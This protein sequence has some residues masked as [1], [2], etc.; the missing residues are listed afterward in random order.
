[1]DFREF[2]AQARKVRLGKRL[3]DAVYLHRSAID[4]LSAE[5]LGQVAKAAEAH[6]DSVDSWN[7]LKISTKNHRITF[8]YYPEFFDD[9]FPSLAASHTVDLESDT[10][11]TASYRKSKNPPILHRCELLLKPDHPSAEQLAEITAQAEAAGLYENTRRIGFKEQWARAI[12]SKGLTFVDGRFRSTEEAQPS[13]KQ[14]NS[15]EIQRHLTAINRDKLSAPMQVLARHGYLDGGHSVFDY[16]CGRGDD[17]REL[18]AHGIDV[19]GWDPV[20]RPETPR[21]TADF[22]NL[23]FVINVIEDTGER[24]DAL[25]AAFSL[26]RKAL[27]VAAMIGGD[28]TTQKFAAYG[29]GV[30]T[31]RNTFQKYFAQEE[32]RKYLEE[33]LSERAIAVAPGIFIIFRDELEEQVFLSERVRASQEWKQLTRRVAPEAKPRASKSMVERN[34]ELFDDFW[35][36]CLHLGRVPGNSEFDHSDRL[37]SVAGSHRKAFEAAQDFYDDEFELAEERRRNELLV[38]FAMESFGRR[39]PYVA[40]PESLQRDIKSFFGKYSTVSEESKRILYSAADTGRILKACEESVVRLGCGFM[41]PGHSLTLHRSLL[42]E[43]PPLLQV[44]VGCATQLYG[45]I[46]DIDLVK[47]HTTSGKVSLLEFDDFVGLPIPSLRRRTKINLRRLQVDVFRY[48][49]D[50]DFLPT[51]LLLKSRFMRDGFPKFKE[52]S[53]FDDQLHRLA[54]LQLLDTQS[55]PTAQLLSQIESY[56]YAID[57]FDIVP[58]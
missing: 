28:A 11:R 36:L 1:M 33:A 18:E 38:Y 41:E 24:T 54:W 39:R 13:S 14:N 5:L 17:I 19:S 20:Y 21:V 56:G 4:G 15:V 48:D 51:P 43:L 16:G 7:V 49:P 42:S 26:A 27:V 31:A 57:G 23:G 50:G 55:R 44:Y 30:V 47:I 10:C 34:P 46:D 12:S 53:A 52:Q 6:K 40:M 9:P 2:Q 3:P 37:R 25:L 58:L 29:D 32:L 45:D 8:L 35:N 22:V